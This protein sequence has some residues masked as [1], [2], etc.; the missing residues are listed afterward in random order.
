[1][2]VIEY[3]KATSI[4]YQFS[5]VLGMLYEA[6]GTNS[7]SWCNLQTK[8]S[9]LICDSK[10]FKK[11]ASIVSKL[12]TLKNIIYFEEDGASSDSGNRN[13]VS[14][15]RVSS[16]YEVEKL[17]K[18]NPTDPR[19]PKKNDIAVIM[20]TSGSTGLPK[21]CVTQ[22]LVNKKL[23]SNQ[24]CTFIEIGKCCHWMCRQS[25]CNPWSTFTIKC[26]YCLLF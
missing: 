15:L 1:M 25:L 14:D 8:V 17:G 19:L 4:N 6:D 10:Q 11:A 2:M 16:L 22:I 13:G 20:Y 24:S 18:D 3:T 7:S 26:V 23:V 12:E 5:Q 21:V 9:T